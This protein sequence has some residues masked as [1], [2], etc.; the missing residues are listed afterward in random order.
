MEQNQI[1]MAKVEPTQ[2]VDSD[3]KV[4]Q[5]TVPPAPL[6]RFCKFRGDGC[7]AQLME[8]KLS[9]HEKYCSFQMVDCESFGCDQ[10][11]S[12]SSTFMSHFCVGRSQ[13]CKKCS[14]NVSLFVLLGST[15]GKAAHKM[16]MKLTKDFTIKLGQPLA[17]STFQRHLLVERRSNF[18]EQFSAVLLHKVGMH[19]DASA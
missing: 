16:L 7:P 12:I 19:Q 6:L 11:V 14:Q 5:S 3:A 4:D 17:E 18:Y 15:C 2:R 13:N 10:K 8:P 1:P 9:E